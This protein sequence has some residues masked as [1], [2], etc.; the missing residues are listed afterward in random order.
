MVGVILG[1]AA[2]LAPVWWPVVAVV[3]DF[4]RRKS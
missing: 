1:G 2:V 3:A 4:L